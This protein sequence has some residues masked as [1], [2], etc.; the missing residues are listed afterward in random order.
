MVK[1]VLVKWKQKA[2]SRATAMIGAAGH[3]S[4]PCQGRRRQGR[5]G[6]GKGEDAVNIHGLF[7]LDSKQMKLFLQVRDLPD[8][9]QAQVAALD[10]R[11]G[12]GRQ[13]SK[14]R[15]LRL[16]RNDAP[17]QRVPGGRAG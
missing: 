8:G 1:I 7:A 15:D 16:R 13:K 2:S 3:P 11:L 9:H 12:K 17:E 5:G 4:R 6:T 10:L 14:G